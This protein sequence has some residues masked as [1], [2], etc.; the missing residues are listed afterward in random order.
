MQVQFQVAERN[1][2]TSWVA[3]W[4]SRILWPFPLSLTRLIFKNLFLFN[5]RTIDL[6]CCVGFCHISTRISHRR[7]CPHLLEPLSHRPLHH[8]ALS[9]HRA[10]GWAPCI[11]QQI[12]TGYLFYIW[13]YMFQCY[14]IPPLLLPLGPWVCS[15]CL[16]LHCSIAHRFISTIFLDS[17]YMH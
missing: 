8:S 7:T 1:Q 15:L 2:K 10:P 9:S 5:W 11:I 16:H 14:S 17:M 12:S 3:S 4:V 13:K 6:Q